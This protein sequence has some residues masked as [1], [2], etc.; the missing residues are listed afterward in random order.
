[1]VQASSSVARPLMVW[2]LTC[3]AVVCTIMSSPTRLPSAITWMLLISTA[4]VFACTLISSIIATCAIDDSWSIYSVAS[5]GSVGSW[6]WISA[7]NSVR[8][9]STGE[10]SLLLCVS[11]AATLLLSA[12][13][14]GCGDCAFSARVFI[15][16]LPV[17]ANFAAYFSRC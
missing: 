13:A 7:T 8:K 16:L 2:P 14:V 6:F 1:M 4:L 10:L 12:V 11:L 5:V 3:K 17:S 9:V 15:R